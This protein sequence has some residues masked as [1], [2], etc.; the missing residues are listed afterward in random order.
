MANYKNI[1]D[2]LKRKGCSYIEMNSN[3][4]EKFIKYISKHK[5]LEKVEIKISKSK[6][7]IKPK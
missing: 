6:L 4:A 5:F 1:L 3:E 2:I 7:I